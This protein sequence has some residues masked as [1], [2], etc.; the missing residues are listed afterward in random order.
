MSTVQEWHQVFALLKQYDPNAE[1]VFA[2]NNHGHNDI[3][4][5]IEIYVDPNRIA[6]DHWVQLE[7]Q[8]WAI[9]KDHVWAWLI[10]S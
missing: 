6:P 8:G 2:L 5:A 1:V 10:E 9:A 7:Q 4:V 3:D